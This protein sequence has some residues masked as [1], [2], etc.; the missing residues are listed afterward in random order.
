MKKNFIWNILGVTCNAF[1]SFFLM[2]IVTRVNGIEDAGVFTFAF[3]FA[4]LLFTIGIFAGRTF[5]VTD[6]QNYSNKDYIFHR[7]L[8]VLLMLLAALIY[9]FTQ[10]YSS[11]KLQIVLLL[12]ILK[13]Q[14]AF[15]DTIYG[16]FQIKG[17]LYKA[18]IS[19]FLKAVISIIGFLFVDLFSR[20]MV[21]SCVVMNVIWAIIFAFYDIKNLNSEKQN[22]VLQI[23][24]GFKL[25]D[26]GKYAFFFNFL[27]IY[28]V[29][30]PKYTMDGCVS[31][32]VQAV[33][34]IIL[35]PATL[36]SLC[37]QYILNPF[38]KM[39][40]DAYYQKNKNAFRR[41]V[42][43][44][45]FALVVLGGMAVLVMIVFGIDLLS[46]VYSVE[47]REYLQNSIW[48]LVGGTLYA[49]TIIFSTALTTLRKTFIQFAINLIVAAIGLLG[50]E[51]MIKTWGL[52]G[53]TGIYCLIMLSQ[54]VMYIG[55][56]RYY[57]K[58]EFCL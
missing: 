14:E 8:C 56:Y 25:F 15:C 52:N 23:I 33:F 37:G 57:L 22:E 6:N 54:C 49:V 42:R 28:I 3:S 39:M 55:V 5:Q 20:N 31:S 2:I 35:M 7:F 1:L 43:K 44:M 27:S 40:K 13:A 58:R 53:A 19:M 32:E 51:F 36:V 47:L 26:R 21:L 50:S 38:L 11:Y 30:A 17:H 46:M 18:G 41:I 9:V 48:I 4:C 12:C 16:I 10:N 34:G 29:N 24:H 45:V